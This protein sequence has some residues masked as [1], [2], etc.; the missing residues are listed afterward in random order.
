MANLI[1]AAKKENQKI[2]DVLLDVN[3]FLNYMFSFYGKEGI[4]VMVHRD[5]HN[6]TLDHLYRAIFDHIRSVTWSFDGDSIDREAT[7]DILIH[8]YGYSFPD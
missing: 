2:L 5:G 6:L 7:R 8:K 1:T 3:D 4:Y